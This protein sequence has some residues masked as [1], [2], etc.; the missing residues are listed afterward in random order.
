MCRR[1]IEPCIGKWTLPAGYLE[2][3]ETTAECAL[4]ESREEAEAALKNL[5][6]YAL[7]NLPFIDQVYFMYRAD[8]GSEHFAPGVE[9]QEVKL[10]KPEDI[11][12]S[13]I[14]FTVISEVLLLYLQDR[15]MN[16]FPFRV[17]DVAPP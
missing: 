6:P 5:H 15:T 3:N 1:A 2:N 16:H 8:L 13:E 4:R 11:P 7:L 9:S 17:V 14:A 10:F 12:W